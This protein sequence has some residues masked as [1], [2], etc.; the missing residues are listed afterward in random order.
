MSWGAVALKRINVLQ[1]EK[2]GAMV[3][4]IELAPQYLPHTHEG[5]PHS[6]NSLFKY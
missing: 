6:S 2:W 1:G 4:A 5:L 3:V